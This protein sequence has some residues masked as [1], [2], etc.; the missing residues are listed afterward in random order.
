MKMRAIHAVGRRITYANVTASLA[1]IVALG[2]TSYAAFK[3]PKNSV[4]SAQLKRGAV[5][6]TDIATG[7][8]GIRHLGLSVRA[9]LGGG[10]PGPAGP[11]GAP[12][13]KGDAGP[14]LT[15]WATLDVQSPSN[16]KI[17]TGSDNVIANGQPDMQGTWRG[18][19]RC[20]A[21]AT[22]Q[23]PLNQPE[24]GGYVALADASDRLTYYT[25]DRA[26]NQAP[27]R[28]YVA[29]YCR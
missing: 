14:G 6:S 7:Q 2:G 10:Q 13:P 18:S 1:L 9:A 3:L 23:A 15:G 11:Q 26:G 16:A 12:G 22:V 19:D 4:G 8:I 24:N 28:I 21:T 25:Y 27:R 17:V 20:A 29:V 5:R